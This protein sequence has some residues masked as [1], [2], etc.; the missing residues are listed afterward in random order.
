MIREGFSSAFFIGGLICERQAPGRTLMAVTIEDLY[1]NYGLLADASKDN[2]SQ[3]NKGI[4][5]HF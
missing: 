1:R 2:I 5:V 3:V 4:C